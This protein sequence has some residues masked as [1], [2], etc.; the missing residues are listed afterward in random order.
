MKSLNVMIAILATAFSI[1]AA[2][3][4]SPARA[5]AATEDQPVVTWAVRPA[6]EAGADGRAWA[7]LEVDAGETV[8][9]HAVVENL[10]SADAQFALSA[11]DGYFTER[12]R[13]NMLNSSE[14]SVG[15]GTWISLPEAV[16]VP[17]RSAVVVPFTVA[18]PDNASPG[19]HAAGVAASVVQPG[20]PG[21]SA[22][23][24]E[25]R[26]GFRVM[27]RV[28]GVAKPSLAVGELETDIGQSWNPFAP[29]TVDLTYRATN[30]GNMQVAFAHQVAGEKAVPRGELLPGESR[31]SRVT[32]TAWPLF[33]VPLDLRVTPEVTNGSAE[34]APVTRTVWVWIIPWS[35]LLVLL[36]VALI[37]AGVLA[38]RGRSRRKIERL[39]QEARDEARRKHSADSQGGRTA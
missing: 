29:A 39:L 16:T 13:F 18:V 28:S 32:T 15:A 9:D 36:G 38:G 19:D 17:A 6:T 10:G 23:G 21:S 2:W 30:D 26:V 27:L 5:D 11:A 14:E 20:T 1:T 31:R 37:I 3:T 4:L 33:I 22:V 24:V 34:I 7:E 25:S 12:G 35:Q 8:V